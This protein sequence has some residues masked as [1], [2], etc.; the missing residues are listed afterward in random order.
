MTFPAEHQNQR[1]VE[2]DPLCFSAPSLPSLNL[3]FG[4][5]D[6]TDKTTICDSLRQQSEKT[7]A[8]YILRAEQKAQFAIC[9]SSLYN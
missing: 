7:E 4:Y 5:A 6:M 8:E 3:I 9:N 2:W 1:S